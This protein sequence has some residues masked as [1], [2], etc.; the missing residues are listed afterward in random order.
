MIAALL[1][2]VACFAAARASKL[3]AGRPELGKDSAVLLR[4]GSTKGDITI[5]L[6]PEWSP[7]GVEQVLKMVDDGFFE[8][9]VGLFR[10][11]P[12]FLVQ[13]GIPA[14]A[15]MRSKWRRAIISDDPDL[16]VPFHRGTLSFAGG[17]PNSRTAQLFIN[18]Q[19]STGLGKSPWETPL[20][21]VQPESLAAV[22]AWFTGYG[23]MPPWGKGPQQGLIQKQGNA[24][25]EREFP[26]LDYMQHCRRVDDE[27]AKGSI[28]AA[29]EAE[30]RPAVGA[31]YFVRFDVRLGVASYGRFVVRVMPA[32]APLGAA[33]FMELVK[34]GFFDE[35]D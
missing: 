8:E 26:L 19:D 16:R 29:L 18:Y 31:A 10:A 3:P 24:Y 15:E 4:C 14:D 32:L 1:L 7:L 21:F 11:V 25:L 5:E 6:R 30:A 20:G 22:D 17:G 33:R 23:D 27:V 13:F 9:P 2:G 35:V 34:A 12:N 28:K